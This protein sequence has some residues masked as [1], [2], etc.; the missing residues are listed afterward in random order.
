MAFLLQ[1]EKSLF[2]HHLCKSK[3]GSLDIRESLLLLVS[4]HVL[5]QYTC[6][7]CSFRT[8]GIKPDGC[9]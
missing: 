4:D 1:T 5:K 2:S 7:L 6:R 9:E 3:K 8:F